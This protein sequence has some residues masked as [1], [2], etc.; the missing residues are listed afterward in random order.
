MSWISHNRQIRTTNVTCT[1]G[2]SRNLLF[3]NTA[4]IDKCAA[5]AVLHNTPDCFELQDFA[6]ILVLDDY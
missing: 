1:R 3:I 6:A 5:F 4:V 2:V